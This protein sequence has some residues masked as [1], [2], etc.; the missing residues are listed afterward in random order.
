MIHPPGA[1]SRRCT[2]AVLREAN[3]DAAAV[4]AHFD[5]HASSIFRRTDRMFAVLMM[6]QWGVAIALAYWISPSTWNGAERSI[7]P[8]LIIAIVGGGLL[9]CLPVATALMLPGRTITRHVIA[10][11]Q[12]LFSSLLIH[13]S[14]GRIETHFHIFGSFAFLAAYRD[15]KVLVAPTLIVA[16]DHI[17]RGIWWPESVFGIATASHWVWIEHTSWLMFEEIVLLITIRQSVGEMRFLAM[18]TVQLEDATRNAEQAN[19]AKSD[20]LASMSHELRTPLNGV[21]GMTELLADSPLDDRQRRFVD[22]CQSSGRS[23]LKLISDILDLSKIEAGCMELEDHP[24]DL[25]QLLDDVMLSMPVR[26]DANRVKIS[27]QFDNPP[28]LCL[29]GDSHRLRQILLNLLSNAIKFTERG[30]I[31]LNVEVQQLRS[32]KATL[33]FSIK[34][35]GIGIPADRL[36]RLFQS[37]S[38]VDSSVSRKYGGSG[39]GLSISKS[40]V[41]KMK[42]QMGVESNEGVGSRFWFTA[43][44]RRGTAA[45]GNSQSKSHSSL[46]TP[47]MDTQLPSPTHEISA[48]DIAPC[49]TARILV[50]DDNEVNQLLACELITRCGWNCDVVGNGVDALKALDSQSYDVVLMDCQ[51]PLLDGY[52]TTMEIRKRETDGRIES[53][54]AIVAL[55]ANAIQSDRQRCLDAGMDDYISKPFEIQQ[56]R[57]TVGRLLVKRLCV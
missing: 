10:I 46:D 8:H 11:S 27:C 16:I 47:S 7:H 35:T 33:L 34:D 20:F 13:L 30:E 40:I 50:A 29:E 57:E 45:D 28:G 26:V 15:W 53:G 4:Q 5:E 32:E 51:M 38:Q 25:Q 41:E 54:P 44:F 36:G 21:I 6:L 9:T 18:H 31:Q 56:L 3:W 39:L 23:L 55:T 37:F 43:T 22:A 24:F 52:L 42:G 14:G 19:Q 49:D 17:V 48:H 12:V 2:D 1:Y